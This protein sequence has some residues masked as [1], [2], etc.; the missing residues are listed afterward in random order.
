MR[1]ID[2]VNLCLALLSLSAC[3]QR[4]AQTLSPIPCTDST[5]ASTVTGAVSEEGSNTP[6]Q[7]RVTIV[8]LGASANADKQG[9]FRLNCVAPGEYT[10]RAISIGYEAD[11][12]KISLPSG[13][14][15][16]VQLVLRSPGY[17]GPPTDSAM[18]HAVW[19]GV[20]RLYQRGTPT[21]VSHL[22]EVARVTG[23]APQPIPDKPPLVLRTIGS[24]WQSP[25]QLN[26][27]DSLQ[28]SGVI[29]GACAHNE[30]SEC[31]D[32]VFSSFVQLKIPRYYNSADSVSV[33]IDETVLNP[34]A[35]KKRQGMGD[36]HQFAVVLAKHEEGWVVMRRVGIEL[37]GGI[38]CGT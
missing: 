27:V 13:T 18:W 22:A 19:T 36:N 29:A 34:R 24:T 35:C 11:V 28:R 12:Q 10:L 5:R 8:E 37:M 9:R 16:T 32:T 30:V 3:T 4:T 6:I 17:T 25:P 7:A 26:W 15:V 21:D 33:A 1:T 14:T 20:L 2:L 38:Y 31:P 23:Q